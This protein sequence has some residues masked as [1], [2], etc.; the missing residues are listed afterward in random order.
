MGNRRKLFLPTGFLVLTAA[1][2]PADLKTGSDVRGPVGG[3]GRDVGLL[4][5]NCQRNSN[6]HTENITIL[7]QNMLSN[8][9][10]DSICFVC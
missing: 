5:S 1:S 10:K 9:C 2:E 6:S 3:V 8:F 7:R 4:L